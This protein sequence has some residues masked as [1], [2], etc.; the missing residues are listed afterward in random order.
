[1][2]QNS[3]NQIQNIQNQIIT[4]INE[5]VVLSCKKKEFIPGITEIPTS[6]KIIGL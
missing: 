6:G 5:F 3:Y 1:M 2:S 4:L